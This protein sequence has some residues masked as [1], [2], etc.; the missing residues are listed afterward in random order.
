M[1]RSVPRCLF[2]CV[3]NKDGLCTN[4]IVTFAYGLTEKERRTIDE[5]STFTKCPNRKLD[6]DIGLKEESL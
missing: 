3:Y 6:T 1:S 5:Q 2:E 4:Q